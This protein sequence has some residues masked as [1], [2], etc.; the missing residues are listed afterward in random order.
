MRKGEKAKVMV[1]PAWG[2]AMP[3]Y[4]NEVQF[5]KGWES[6]DRRELL[7]RRRAFF[8]IKLHDWTIRNDV[9]GDGKIVKTVH[10]RGYGMD[11]PGDFDEIQLALKIFQGDQIFC[12]YDC[13]ELYMT[14][15]KIVTPIVFK[16]LTTMKLEERSTV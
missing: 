12:D 4:T 10:S 5:P 14:N 16:V 8:E 2:Y 15:K 6:G 9:D 1:K 11:R 7:L 13:I 3:E